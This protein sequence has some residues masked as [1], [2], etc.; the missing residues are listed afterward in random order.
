MSLP[1]KLEHLCLRHS[2]LPVGERRCTKICA[3]L[4]LQAR[5]RSQSG[6][7][8][9]HPVHTSQTAGLG[10]LEQLGR[11]GPQHVSDHPRCH[12]CQVRPCGSTSR[13]TGAP[14]PASAARRCRPVGAG[15]ARS[16]RPPRPRRRPGSARPRPGCRQPRVA[17]AR[18]PA[19]GGPAPCPRD[20]RTPRRR[21]TPRRPPDLLR[22]A[23]RAPRT[24]PRPAHP[25]GASPERVALGPRGRRQGAQADLATVGHRVG[26]QC[27]GGRP[28]SGQCDGWPCRSSASAA[29]GLRSRPA[30][31]RS[32]RR[33]AR[34][35]CRAFP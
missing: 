7:G 14:G 11:L 3:S 33:R 1:A 32:P 15:P 20:G 25:G 8:P 19:H 10:R 9:L 16:P 18:Q 12:P 4:R 21:Q 22:R 24:R 26:G 5:R 35:R 6:Q 29:T 13:T 34:R 30:P 31:V 27:S 2:P 23:G 17:R 28:P